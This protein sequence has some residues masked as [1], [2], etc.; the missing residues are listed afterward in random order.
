MVTEEKPNHI[1]S[2]RDDLLVYLAESAEKIPAEKRRKLIPGLCLLL[3][4]II[5]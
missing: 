3:F 1:K 4:Q 5:M 2:R